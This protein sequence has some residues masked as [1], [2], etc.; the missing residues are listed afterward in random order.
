M[1]C[2]LGTPSVAYGQNM[3]IKS[4][5]TKEWNSFQ[6]KCQQCNQRWWCAVQ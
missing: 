3:G 5:K 4:I 1:Y 6:S 2:S